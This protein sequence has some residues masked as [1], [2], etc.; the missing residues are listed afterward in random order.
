M[1][2]PPHVRQLHFDALTSTAEDESALTP[3]DDAEFDWEDHL[4]MTRAGAVSPYRYSVD[5]KRYL[6]ADGAITSPTSSFSTQSSTDLRAS[7][8]SCVRVT[9]MMKLTRK[10]RMFGN[11]STP[12]T[13]QSTPEKKRWYRASR[14]TSKLQRSSSAMSRRP[15]TASSIDPALLIRKSPI[16][17]ED[18]F[19]VPPPPPTGTHPALRPPAARNAS[20]GTG[21]KS[22]MSLD[23][24]RPSSSVSRRVSSATRPPS[25]IHPALSAARSIGER[26]ARARKSDPSRPFPTPAAPQIDTQPLPVIWTIAHDRAICVLDARNYTTEQSIRKLR[27]AFPE[28]IGCYLSPTMVERRLQVL[29]QNP[30]I[31]YFRVGLDFKSARSKVVDTRPQARLPDRLSS[32]TSTSSPVSAISGYSTSSTSSSSPIN[33]RVSKTGRRKAGSVPGLVSETSLGKGGRP[34]SIIDERPGSVVSNEGVTALPAEPRWTK[35]QLDLP[36]QSETERDRATDKQRVTHVLAAKHN[37]EEKENDGVDV[38]ESDKKI[39]RRMTG[40]RKLAKH[41]HR[42]TGSGGSFVTRAASRGRRSS[43]LNRAIGMA[44]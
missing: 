42:R 39:E 7:L 20:D 32:T 38:H 5:I 21:R 4:H 40:L 35:P 1:S 10:D 33:A 11:E 17:F 18:N 30:D 27:R 26:V 13:M 37:V 31:D 41:G 16:E 44:L 14:P 36:I 2:A 22:S 23:I 29:D 25:K 6:D 34:M 15:S 9:T 19:T 43:E 3:P 8:V 12:T 28:L 24:P